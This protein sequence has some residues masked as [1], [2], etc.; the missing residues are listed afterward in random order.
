[1]YDEHHRCRL[2][3]GKYGLKEIGAFGF[4]LHHFLSAAVVR[5]PVEEQVADVE[6]GPEWGPIVSA[7]IAPLSIASPSAYKSPCHMTG[8]LFLGLHLSGPL[9]NLLSSAGMM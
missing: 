1:L 6:E 8:M 5:I 3:K 7:T 2:T 9:Q 4:P